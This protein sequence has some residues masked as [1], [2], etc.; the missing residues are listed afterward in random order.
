MFGSINLSIWH[1][2]SM[3]FLLVRVCSWL[4][5]IC[6]SNIGE[7]PRAK[8]FCLTSTLW[9]HACLGC[10][11]FTHNWWVSD[12]Q[13]LRVCCGSLWGK[14]FFGRT[15]NA[16]RNQKRYVKNQC[17]KPSIFVTCL[18]SNRFPKKCHQLAMRPGLHQNLSGISFPSGPFLGWLVQSSNQYIC[19]IW[20]YVCAS[21]T[22]KYIYICVRVS[23][24]FSDDHPTT[25]PGLRLNSIAPNSKFRK[26]VPNI[27]WRYSKQIVPFSLL[28][29][30]EWCQ[31]KFGHYNYPL[32]PTKYFII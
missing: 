26:H 25:L 2:M 30:L 18:K 32:H 11:P 29:S 28:G 14:Q 17:P 22:F 16:I 10:M 7:V 4:K 19:Y 20:K 21:C 5:K 12:G 23:F 13:R 1:C 8:L 31:P 3:S 9:A 27:L 6:V 24:I 15:R